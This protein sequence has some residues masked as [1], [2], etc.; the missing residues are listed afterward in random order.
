MHPSHRDRSGGGIHQASQETT[1]VA[2][3]PAEQPSS[4]KD[5]T[6]FGTTLNRALCHDS[7]RDFLVTGYSRVQDFL[8]NGD[9]T[10]TTK[11]WYEGHVAQLLDIVTLLSEVSTKTSLVE[12]DVLAPKL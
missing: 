6:G 4:A 3:L 9:D 12:S 8:V 10:Y 5:R 2:G 7:V 11:S 1:T